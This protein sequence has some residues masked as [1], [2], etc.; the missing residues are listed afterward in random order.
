M[1]L[2]NWET[3]HT[4]HD[5]LETQLVPTVILLRAEKDPLGLNIEVLPAKRCSWAAAPLDRANLTGLVLG[6]IEAK[7]CKKICV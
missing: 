5:S 7:V 6:C 1:H 3:E 2:P 4:T